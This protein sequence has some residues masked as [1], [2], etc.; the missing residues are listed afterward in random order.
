MGRF[1]LIIAMAYQQLD[2]DEEAEHFVNLA[3][4]YG[5]SSQLISEML[6]ASAH[7]TMSRI[8]AI[9]NNK[10]MVLD[11]IRSA[12][13]FGSPSDDVSTLMDNYSTEVYEKRATKGVEFS[14]NRFLNDRNKTKIK[15]KSHSYRRYAAFR[16]NSIV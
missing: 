11:H 14:E 9:K 13:F 12:M 10:K 2:Q 15:T 1:A 6:L 4:E 8:H 7:T 3:I 16:A 5:C